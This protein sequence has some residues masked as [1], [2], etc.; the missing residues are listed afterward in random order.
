MLMPIL[1]RHLSASA[2]G[3]MNLLVTLY[4]LAI[5]II[6]INLASYIYRV[7][8]E[9]GTISRE[10][11]KTC[12]GVVVRWALI[13]GTIA[14]MTTIF[15]SLT[16]DFP[17]KYAFT[18][19]AIVFSAF[20]H[21]VYLTFLN[22]LSAAN[23]PYSFVKLQLLYTIT[24]F[25]VSL[26]FIIPLNF[27]YLGRLYGL[28]FTDFLF[29]IVV[30]F[31]LGKYLSDGSER[32]SKT[33][34]KRDFLVYGFGFLPHAISAILLSSVDKLVIATKINLEQLGYYA[35]A[36]QFTSIL[37]IFTQ[38]ISKEWSRSFLAAPYRQG[39]YLTGS[40]YISSILLLALLLY[41][42][43]GLFYS[44]FVGDGFGVQ[45]S[46]IAVLI[47]SY[48]FHS[49]YI[50]LSVQ[51]NLSK[52]T[53]LLS[54]FTVASVLINI[55]VSLVLVESMGLLGVAVGT[56][57]GMLCKLIFASIYVIVARKSYI[58]RQKDLNL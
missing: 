33:E 39:I 48:C 9:N 56:A 2:Y 24:I 7:F 52:K 17:M 6:S 4:A 1:T 13:I 34:I 21:L 35:V 58:L 28:L 16:F 30:S 19:I 8:F 29:A 18:S 12:L 57:M 50:L 26:L 5:P 14:F 41:Y 10:L 46:L 36:L 23:K 11:F 51:L 53:Y 47:V 40:I 32:K 49:I 43:Q 15:L 25:S 42:S 38:G 31:I 20:S 22:M 44:V 27:G 37:M 45:P 3:S 55:G 54:G